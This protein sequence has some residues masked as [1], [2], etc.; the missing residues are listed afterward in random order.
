MVTNAGVMV[1][2]PSKEAYELSAK[3]TRAKHT[4]GMLGKR[5]NRLVVLARLADKVEPSG[6]KKAWWLVRCDC[7]NTVEIT[8]GQ[9]DKN[10]SCGCYAAEVSRARALPPHLKK[11]PKLWSECPPEWRA[12]HNAARKNRNR[13]AKANL[14]EEQRNAKNA[15][16]RVVAK[17]RRDNWTVAEREAANTVGRTRYH[18]LTSEQR[19]GYTAARHKRYAENPEKLERRNSMT[20]QWYE[21]NREYRLAKKKQNR[22]DNPHAE[23]EYRAV[24]YERSV[25]NLEGDTYIRSLLPEGLKYHPDALMIKRTQIQIKRYMKENNL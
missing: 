15:A 1:G 9:F 14:T 18:N 24:Y 16:A 20:K 12:K 13:I 5:S 3:L 7:G 10:V 11:K 4:V 8:T 25:T 19:D 21:D 17:A 22:L 2:M 6:K 23:D